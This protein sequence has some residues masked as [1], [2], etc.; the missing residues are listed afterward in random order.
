MGTKWAW[1]EGGKWSAGHL[2]TWFVWFSDTQYLG[3]LKPWNFYARY[4]H[5]CCLKYPYETGN[6][7][8]WIQLLISDKNMQT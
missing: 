3:I 2:F 7:I 5:I 8:S 4:S 1:A 6:R